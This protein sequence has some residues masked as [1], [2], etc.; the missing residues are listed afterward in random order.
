MGLE[1]RIA[2]RDFGLHIPSAS[3]PRYTAGMLLPAIQRFLALC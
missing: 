1:A 2:C 3:V